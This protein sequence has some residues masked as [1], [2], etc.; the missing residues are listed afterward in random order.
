MATPM[1]R[2]LKSSAVIP[3]STMASTTICSTRREEGEENGAVRGVGL[4]PMEDVVVVVVVVG[5]V[6][7]MW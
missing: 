5:G 3:S 1:G 2:V 7:R 4:T 6:Q